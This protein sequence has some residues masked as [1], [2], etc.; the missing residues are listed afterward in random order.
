MASAVSRSDTPAYATQSGRPPVVNGN[1]EICDSIVLLDGSDDEPIQEELEQSVKGSL[2]GDGSMLGYQLSCWLAH[3][4]T[5]PAEGFHKGSLPRTRGSGDHVA[6]HPHERTRR[7][8]IYTPLKKCRAAPG[9]PRS[10][11]TSAYA[12]T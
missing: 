7:N 8:G 6:L 1:I 10:D 3:K 9:I 5:E 4:M 2:T 12:L 11:D